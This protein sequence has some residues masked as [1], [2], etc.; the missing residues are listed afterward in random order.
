MLVGTDYVS[1]STREYTLSSLNGWGIKSGNK[2]GQRPDVWGL[3][4]DGRELKGVGYYMNTEA[5]RFDL[6]PKGLKVDFNPST[7]LHPFELIT[8]RQTLAKAVDLVR[9]QLD[10]LGIDL[11]L[12]RAGVNR[13]DLTKQ[14]PLMGGPAAYSD[15]WGGLNGKRMQ[16]SR[17]QYPDGFSMGNTQRQAVFYNKE[18]QLREAKRLT[19]TTPKDLTRAEVRW[20]KSKSAANTVTGAGVG[21]L[22]HLLEA[23]PE[24]LTA[25]YNRFLIKDVFRTPDGW[26]AVLDLDWSTEVDYLRNLREKHPRGAFDQYLKMEGAEAVLNRFGSVD[27]LQAALN[28]AGYSRRTVYRKL[29]ELQQAITRKGFLDNRRGETSTAQKIDHLRRVFCS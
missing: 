10:S 8:D 17:A 20:T 3:V 24:A 15:V 23:E 4:Q 13:L 21:R 16:R 12:N 29:N 14:A 22:I 19:I 6:S 18:K 28:Q 7:L 5:A 11:D 25:A 27:L 2:V 26:Q 1:L 9:V